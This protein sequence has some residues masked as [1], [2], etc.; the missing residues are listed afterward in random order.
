M[1]LAIIA[2]IAFFIGWVLHALVF[3]KNIQKYIEKSLKEKPVMDL[4]IFSNNGELNPTISFTANAVDIFNEQMDN[5]NVQL[6]PIFV[7]CIREDTKNGH[8]LL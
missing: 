4:Y 7:H 1:E 6:M 2:I 5:G 3:K 8:L